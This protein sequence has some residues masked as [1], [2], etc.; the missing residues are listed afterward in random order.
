MSDSMPAGSMVDRHRSRPATRT[1]ASACSI[2]AERK[3][4]LDAGAGDAD[5]DRAV[6]HAGDE[7]AGHGIARGRVAELLVGGRGRHRE[8][9]AGDDLA[10]FQR[11]GKEAGEEILGRERAPVG[12]D[13]G[14]ERQRR[15]R[16][17]GGRIVV[18]QRA[19]DGAHLAHGR[20]ADRAG[21]LGKRGNR[22]PDRRRGV[23]LGMGRGGADGRPRRQRRRCPSVRRCRSSR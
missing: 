18:G 8:G 14:A 21:E 3:T 6:L 5:A 16:I 15:G 10:V 23:D 4:P 1:A 9:D 12:V 19:A 13:G 20:I 2:A 22:L 11:G 7:D 17:V